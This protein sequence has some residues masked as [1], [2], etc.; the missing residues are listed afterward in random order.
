MNF[1]IVDEFRFAELVAAGEIV[2]DKCRYLDGLKAGLH[3]ATLLKLESAGGN[4]DVRGVE[5]ELP[6]TLRPGQFFLGITQERLGISPRLFGWI[7]TRSMWARRGLDCLSS[8]TYIAPGFGYDAPDPVPLTLELTPRM[9]LRDFPR[10]E[11][12]A[13]FILFELEHPVRPSRTMQ[14]LGGEV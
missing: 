5:C 2:H 12:V 8:S 6:T 11:P 7:H 3:I 13:A 1:Q 4:E 14:E 10:E 9:L